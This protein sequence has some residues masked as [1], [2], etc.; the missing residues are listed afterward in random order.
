[1]AHYLKP[2]SPEWLEALEAFNPIQAVATKQIIKSAGS[3]E[4][5][6]IC[7]DDEAKD[8]K[9]IANAIPKDAVATIRLCD[10]C[11]KI[12]GSMHG[13]SYELLK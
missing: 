4:V 5:C 2:N 8:Y 12:R 11:L 3:E 13:E 1:M 7:G 6:S 9:I 10:D